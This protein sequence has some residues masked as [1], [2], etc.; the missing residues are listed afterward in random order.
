MAGYHT[1]IDYRAAV[2][3][4]IFATKRGKVIHSGPGGTYGNAYG[5]Y[6]VIES[7][8]NGV[9]R[10]HLYA[11]LSRTFAREGSK[12]R[13]GQPIGLSGETGN[14]FGPHLHYE[15]RTAP[16]TYWQHKAPIYPQWQPKSRKTLDTILKRIG[17]KK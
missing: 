5:N 9:K 15:E 8:I 7:D 3:T 10:Q 6:V 13:T 17:L 16:F 2:G 4:P 12:V 11:H 1:G 14:A